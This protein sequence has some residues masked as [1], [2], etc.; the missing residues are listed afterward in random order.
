MNLS[1]RLQG[2]GSQGSPDD[3][4]IAPYVSLTITREETHIQRVERTLTHAAMSGVNCMEEF[5]ER[6]ETGEFQV[7]DLTRK[8]CMNNETVRIG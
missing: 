3:L 2:S 6:G 8:P 4:K 7:G 5:G 1:H